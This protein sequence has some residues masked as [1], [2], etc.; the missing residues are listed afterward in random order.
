MADIRKQVVVLIDC[1]DYTKPEPN[2]KGYKNIKDTS[3][4]VCE[5]GKDLQDLPEWIK[6]EC[7]TIHKFNFWIYHDLDINIKNNIRYYVFSNIKKFIANNHV[8]LIVD[9]TYDRPIHSILAPVVN[10]KNCIKILELSDFENRVLSDNEPLD[11]YYMGMHWNQC[12]KNRP[13]G[14]ENVLTVVKRKVVDCR[15][16][17][18]PDTIVKM[19][20]PD[21]IEL[22]PTNFNNSG[23]LEKVI[24]NNSI[25]SDKPIWQLRPNVTI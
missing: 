8:D 7:L 3:W 10:S 20:W 16:L 17:F 2:I 4:P 15:I 5:S 12:I 19:S 14:W 1:W 23:D 13:V 24:L 18:D 21:E 22:Y 11:I 25:K 9:A 6:D